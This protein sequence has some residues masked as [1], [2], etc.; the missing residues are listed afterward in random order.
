MASEKA[1][2]ETLAK[3]TTEYQQKQADYAKANA[4]HDEAVKQGETV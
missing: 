3:L 1:D 2:T 4:D